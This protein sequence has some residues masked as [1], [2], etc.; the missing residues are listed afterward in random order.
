MEGVALVTGGARGIGL[1]VCRQ[2]AA[3]GMTVH[4]SARDPGRAETRSRST[5]R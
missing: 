1:E 2:L 3:E 4:L 5:R